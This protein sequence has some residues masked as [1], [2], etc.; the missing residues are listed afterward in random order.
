MPPITFS[1]ESKPESNGSQIAGIIY[2]SRGVGDESKRVERFRT[3]CAP[4]HSCPH[5]QKQQLCP[6]RKE[7]MTLVEKDPDSTEAKIFLELAG[8]LLNQPR[9]YPAQPLSEEQMELFMRGDTLPRP[10]HLFR[11][12]KPA[13]VIPPTPAAPSGFQAGTV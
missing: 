12:K 3:G 5:P 4:S 13:V 7:A 11:K 2:N 1:A 8:K 9:L 6:G 10:Q